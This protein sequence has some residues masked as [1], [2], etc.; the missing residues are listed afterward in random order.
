MIGA[1]LHI[2]TDPAF[3]RKSIHKNSVGRRSQ[4]SSNFNKENKIDL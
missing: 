3:H 1:N 4:S 2:D